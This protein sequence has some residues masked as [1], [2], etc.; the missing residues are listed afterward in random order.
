MDDQGIDEDEIN[1]ES[2]EFRCKPC[3][4]EEAEVPRMMKAPGTPSQKEVEE[5]ELT[6]CPFRSW[7]DHCVKGQAKDGRHSLVTGELGES[8]VVR[9][10]M[11]YCF[12]QEDVKHEESEHGG[13]APKQRWASLPWWS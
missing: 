7:C 8:S 5:H 4:V 2:E 13:R 12:F 9:V 6:H 1:E 10:I 3:G 11:D